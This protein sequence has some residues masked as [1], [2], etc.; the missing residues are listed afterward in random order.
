M[1]KKIDK[2]LIDKLFKISF[3]LFFVISVIGLSIFGFDYLK[4][5]KQKMIYLV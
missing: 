1:K 3:I 4:K 5:I 2:N